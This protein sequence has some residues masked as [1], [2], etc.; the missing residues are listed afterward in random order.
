MKYLIYSRRTQ[1]YDPR[2]KLT[3]PSSITD[4][5]G[6]ELPYGWEVAFAPRVGVYYIDHIRKKNQL[7]DPRV[8]IRNAQIQMLTNYMRQAEPAAIRLQQQKYNK[9][10]FH[11]KSSHPSVALSTPNLAIAS[12]SAL[13]SSRMQSQHNHQQQTDST[14]LYQNRLDLQL[15]IEQC[16][17]RH[18]DQHMIGSQV[19]SNKVS[20]DEEG[21]YVFSPPNQASPGVQHKPHRD[22]AILQQE[23]QESKSRV[24]Q[25]K[26]ELDSNPRVLTF[27]R[28]YRTRSDAQAVE[29]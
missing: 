26:R 8:E 11:L 9:S 6:D 12:V 1:W 3:K 4:C 25:L 17:Q 5:V 15:Q 22:P 18:Q 23:L 24:A 20:P 7:E 10:H 28:R 16:M 29:V 19:T 14:P 21:Q 2:D 13:N 27:M